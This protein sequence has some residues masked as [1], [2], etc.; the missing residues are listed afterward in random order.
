[1]I[2]KITGAVKDSFVELFAENL[3]S[4]HLDSIAKINKVKIRRKDNIIDNIHINMTLKGEQ[5]S[6]DVILSGVKIVTK[7]EFII[8]E[9]DKVEANREWVGEAIK[10]ILPKARLRHM[11][12]TFKRIGFRVV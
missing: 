3:L 9:V 7:G 11:A 10:K 1:M 4:E 2:K 6:L 12:D 5:E 8:P